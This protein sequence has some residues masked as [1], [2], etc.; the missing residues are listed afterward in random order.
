MFYYALR[1]RH[2]PTGKHIIVATDEACNEIY[3]R[4][5]AEKRYPEFVVTAVKR[6][7]REDYMEFLA[8]ANS[9]PTEQP[10]I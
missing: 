1:M 5:G 10:T 9:H 4:V 2:V 3:A 6:I 8:V 7:T